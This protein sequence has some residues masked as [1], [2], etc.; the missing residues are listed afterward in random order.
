MSDLFDAFTADMPLGSFGLTLQADKLGPGFFSSF[1][2][3]G[4]VQAT[5][6]R[7]Y[8]LPVGIGKRVSMGSIVDLG[9][10]RRG[11]DT[12]DRAFGANPKSK[13]GR[14]T[15]DDPPAEGQNVINADD[16][17]I[18]SDDDDDD[19]DEFGGTA[20][21]QGKDLGGKSSPAHGPPDAR[22]FGMASGLIAVA[23]GAVALAAAPAAAPVAAAAAAASIVSGYFSYVAA[24]LA[25]SPSAGD[26]RKMPNPDDGS[27]TNNPGQPFVQQ[28]LAIDGAFATRRRYKKIVTGEWDNMQSYGWIHFGSPRA[29]P[30][31]DGT[32]ERVPSAPIFERTMLAAGLSTGG[33]DQ[34]GDGWMVSKGWA[35]NRFGAPRA[36][37]WGGRIP[38]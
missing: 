38:V 4:L 16:V 13:A 5:E 34:G 8:A 1:D 21:H 11:R 9:G 19:D 35:W 12:R 36:Q 25:P 2:V 10:P 6:E 28:T 27:G 18:V 29:M 37:N 31:D 20:T 24:Y 15:A 7:G 23:V 32:D 22:D 14:R 3:S 26:K 17:W 30:S 33:K